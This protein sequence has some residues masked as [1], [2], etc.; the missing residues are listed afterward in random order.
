MEKVL[1]SLGSL[2]MG[3][4]ETMVVNVLDALDREKLGFD[5]VIP[6][7]EPGYYEERVKK[8]GAKVIHIPRRSESF[9]KFH[10]EFYRAVKNGGYKTVHIHT[11]NAFFTSL[12]VFLARRAGAERILVHSHNTM[13][14][15]SGMAFRLHASC[16]K[17]L[18][19]HTDV[20]LACGREAA[21]WLF[22]TAQGV[23]IL[24]LPVKCDALRFD[25]ERQKK[26]KEEAGL[27]GKTVY[28]HVGRFMDV[29]NHVFLI[30]IF[31]ELHRRQLDSVLLLVGDGELRPQ[32]EE[33]AKAAGLSDSVR[34]LG[35][36]SDVP[37]KMNLADAMIFPS[38]YEGFPTVLLE[39]Q[40]AGLD[41]F[42]SDS[43]TP[44]IKLTDRIH[45]LSLEQSP[46]V[47]AEKILVTKRKPDRA[48]DNEP[49]KAKYDVSAVTRRLT[50]LYTKPLNY[51][52]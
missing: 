29:K 7:A 17:W 20:R 16:R 38:K 2:N 26:L 49:V 39:A 32:I 34:F 40:A 48:A 47:W 10:R 8:L 27:T 25:P 3:G 31:E 50:E 35:N 42:A 30:Q 24:P 52:K 9:W 5:F 19:Q 51:S 46:A 18:Y 45:W 41:C 33:Q 43:I 13:D 6:G 44:E 23:E 11:Q 1:Q 36:L 22:G 28:L 21:E 12:Q 4:A 15:R 37:D 14:W